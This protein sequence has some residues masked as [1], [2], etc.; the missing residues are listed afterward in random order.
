M[1]K[2]NLSDKIISGEFEVI[3]KADAKEF[4]KILKEDMFNLFGHETGG[5]M[6]EING[7]INKR[8]GNKLI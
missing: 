7:I 3:L 1:T 8:A 4:I 5:T 2:F 6:G